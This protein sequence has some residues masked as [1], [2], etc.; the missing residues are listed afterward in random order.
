MNRTPTIIEICRLLTS[1]ER[2]LASQR[3]LQEY[4]AAVAQ[5]KRSAW[6]LHRQVKV[7]VRDHF[8]DR[9]FG[10][11]LVF[12]GTLR[13]ISILLPDEFPYH[14]NW[15]QSETHPAFWE[16]SPTIDHVVPLARGGKDDEFNVVITSMVR[17]AS[18]ANWLVGE[19]N[20]PERLAPV[21]EE[22]DGLL[23][24]FL[25]T[26]ESIKVIQEDPAMRAWYRAAKG[27]A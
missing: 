12:P 26:F 6:P 18:K 1:N 5:T 13:A 25:S 23:P 24:W 21:I 4:P 3:L 19:L 16:L 14:R 10:E 7:C 2:A 15:K 27:V 9:Y 8:T 17:N 20:W 22:W 11:Q